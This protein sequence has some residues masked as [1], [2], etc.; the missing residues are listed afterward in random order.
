MGP[1]S[2]V[3]ISIFFTTGVVYLI[4]Q[5]TRGKSNKREKKTLFKEPL[6]L[7]FD[8][9]FLDEVESKFEGNVYKALSFLDKETP[10]MQARRLDCF[11][12]PDVYSVCEK[13]CLE[14]KECKSTVSVLQEF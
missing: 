7:P 2:I 1:T 14:N 9:D 5:G 12:N 6:D 13:H 10:P 8:E 3:L 11:G 4:F